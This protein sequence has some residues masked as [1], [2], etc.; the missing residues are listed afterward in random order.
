MVASNVGDNRDLA[1]NHIGGVEPPEHADFDHRHLDSL[2]GK[3]QQSRRRDRLEP[4]E[5]L[6]I[7]GLHKTCYVADGLTER[8]LVEF[9]RADPDPFTRRG[10]VRTRVE[11]DSQT[12]RGQQ[13]LDHPRGRAL[14]VGS[15][16]VDRRTGVLGIAQNL[17]DLLHLV[18]RQALDGAS[19]RLD[20]IVD[21]PVKMIESFQ[22]VQDSDFRGSPL[23]WRASPLRDQ[24][25]PAEPSRGRCLRR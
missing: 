15:G 1:V 8:R 19:T 21:Q 9:G 18:Q 4:A 16:Y 20:F 3:M 24:P 2:V 14:A 5:R 22:I 23:N 11:P 10:D 17:H 6:Q 25:A 7:R 12:L 13:R